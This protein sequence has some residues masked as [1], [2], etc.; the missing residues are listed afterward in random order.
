MREKEARNFITNP[1]DFKRERK[2][3]FEHTVYLLTNLLKKSLSVEIYEFFNS[4]GATTKEYSKSAFTQQRDKLSAD[5][6]ASW[7]VKLVESFYSHYQERVKRWH[8]YRL[9]AIDGSTAYLINKPGL[10]AYFGVQANQI[11]EVVMGQIMSAYDVLNGITIGACLLPIRYSEQFIVNKWVDSFEPDMLML[12]DRG[13]PSF[14][15]I[16]LHL[17]QEQPIT[18]VMRCKTTFNKEVIEFMQEDVTSKEV[19]FKA[20]SSAIEELAKHGYKIN[21]TTSIKVRL[22]KVVLKDGFTEVLITNLYDEKQYPTKIFKSLYFTRWGIETNYGTQK[23]KLQLECFSGYKVNSILQDFYANIFVNNLQSIISKPAEQGA[24][25]KTSNRKYTYKINQNVSI[26]IMKHKIAELFTTENP[27]DI[28]TE[29]E[30]LFLRNLEPVRPDRSYER[31]VK[32][33]RKN[34]SGKKVGE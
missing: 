34:G 11:K 7:N 28:L 10:K 25:T 8:G 13:Y 24:A 1:T 15:T 9:I 5:F 16:Y 23:N 12:Y 31:V 4:I 30:A 29:L 27:E 2:L 33:K 19:E 14:A 18:F 3:S 20:T 6:F 32:D 22:V 17:S 26:G 21:K